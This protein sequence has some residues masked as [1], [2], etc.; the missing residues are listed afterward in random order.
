MP[1]ILETV[2]NKRTHG[3]V[4]AKAQVRSHEPTDVFT[5]TH[6]CVHTNAQMRSY[7]HTDAFPL[8]Q[9]CV[10]TYILTCLDKGSMF[11]FQ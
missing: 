5:P 7:Q 11:F 10:P 1:K 9:R 8:T 3:C 2:K 6:R 4:R